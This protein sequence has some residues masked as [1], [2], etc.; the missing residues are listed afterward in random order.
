ML[1][2]EVIQTKITP[3]SISSRTLYR[4]RV[5][6]TLAE[7]DQYRLTI[8]QENAGFG[9]STALA[10][11]ASESARTIWYQITEDDNNLPIFLLYLL[12]A[13]LHTIP[14]IKDLPLS[15]LENWD[16]TQGPLPSKSIVNQYINAIEAHI[17]E[18][19]ILIF[20]DIHL[21]QET[22]EIAHTL[23]HLIS[24]APENLHLLLSSRY[25]VKLPNLYRWVS[26]GEV[27]ILD[28]N[29]L[30]FTPDEVSLLYARNFE[31]ELL[32][33]EIQDLT[34]VTEGWA[35]ALLLVWQGLRTGAVTSIEE[36]LT[37]QASTMENLFAVL[38]HEVLDKQPEDIQEFLQASSVLRTMTPNACNAIRNKDDSAAIL[39][40]LQRQ[41]L[42]V[43]NAGENILRYQ[44]I[45]HKLLTQQTSETDRNNWHNLASQYYKAQNDVE[46]AIYHAFRSLDYTQAADLLVIYGEDLIRKGL[47]DT[48]STY[49]EQLPPDILLNHP[50]LL[51]YLGDIARFRSQFQEALG[52]YKQAETIFTE[53]GETAEI[54]RALRG[55]AR[56]YIDTVDPNKASEL[57]QKALRISDGIEDRK[58]SA[59]L[60]ELLAENKLNAGKPEEAEKL[61]NQAQVLRQEGHSESQLLYR[62]LIRTGRLSEVKA[63]LENR[64]VEERNEPVQTSRSHRETQLLL[65]LINALMGDAEISLETARDGTQRGEELGSPWVTAVGHMRQGHALMLLKDETGYSNA[66]KEFEIAIEISRSL[67]TPRLRVEAYWGLCRVFGYSGDLDQATQLAKRAVSIAN[68]AGDEWISSL[69]HLAMG[70]SLIQA[71]SYEI[72]YSW[73]NKALR[74]FRECSDPFGTSATRLWLC[75]GWLS[76]ENIERLS[77]EVPLLMDI[78][79]ENRYDY[80]FTKPTL[81]G[82]PDER[83][84]I[85][86]LIFA[87]E[88]GWGKSYTR[89]LL[90]EIGFPGISTHPGYQL[91]VNTLGKFQAYRGK[92]PIPGTGWQRSKSRQLFQLLITHNDSPLDREQIYEYLW[93]GGAIG[94]TEQNFKVALS[95]LY[96]VL[97]PNRAAGTDSAFIE[98]QECIYKIRD[99][100]DIWI[101]FVDFEE[102]FKT[103]EEFVSISP[104]SAI[105]RYEKALS[106]YKGEYLPDS[107]YETWAAVK[108]EQ[109]SVMFLRGAD[110]LCELYLQFNKSEDTINLCQRIFDEDNCWERAYRHL[111]VAYDQLGDHGQIARTYQRCVQNMQDELGI[112][113]SSE[114]ELHYNDLISTY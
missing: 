91:R 16:V 112:S 14:D 3:P 60:Y 55:Q 92:I 11:F 81:L 9:K 73:L 42:F 58:S 88:Q 32:P 54:G 72:A 4:E 49:L 37:Y 113:P 74:G 95:T 63:K 83:A 41:D 43:V 23:D 106:L 6:N 26:R 30:S 8:L 96:R 77:Q 69:V 101:D 108:R 48:L 10:S 12:K 46:S 33:D 76:E 103:S 71:G 94:K 15:V 61:R 44:H 24:L 1:L 52:W 59:R 57:L 97:E 68:D 20:D 111:M 84:C 62:V 105:Q 5:I 110:R 107:L 7:A 98:R 22:P 104:E 25:P 56:V 35:L 80:L 102:S 89:H 38:T 28:Q 2:P 85:P 13:T 47:L 70:A 64:A 29:L 21:V 99:D 75:L 78:C 36:A 82:L 50:I 17:S 40:Y 114:T 67:S 51:K 109:L 90:S 66:R 18:S 79:Q 87:R 31:Y 27:L 65:S 86:L 39:A 34:T 100:A 93:P 53:R 19:V 45:F